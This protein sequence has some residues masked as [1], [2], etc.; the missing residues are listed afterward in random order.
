MSAATHLGA[1]QPVEQGRLAGV[2]VAD[3]RDDRIGNVGA[4]GAMQRARL[5][6]LLEVALDAD[7]ALL[8][9]APVGLDLGFAGTAEKAEAAALALQV[10][11]GPHQARALIVEMREFDLQRALGGARAAAE[12]L[13]DQPGA[14][15]HLGLER[16]LQIALLH[17]RQRASTTTSVDL[18]GLD[19][20][21]DFGDLAL[22][23]IGRRAGSRARATRTEST[24]SRS[25]ARA[26]PTASSRRASGLRATPRSPGARAVEIGAD[27]Q[28][29]RS[30]G[31][32]LLASAERLSGL[33][34][35]RLNAGRGPLP[36]PRT[37]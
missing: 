28:R 31:D 26:R 23:E 19:P 20:L 29:P 17:R 5:L 33:A 10:G 8:N 13:Q 9:E 11:P 30:R 12:D 37:W 24:T 22:A 15:D 32:R 18:V 7:H 36:P 16:L 4:A 3:Q 14:V 2:G 27:D 34:Q 1:G 25:M 6:H 21:G 35:R